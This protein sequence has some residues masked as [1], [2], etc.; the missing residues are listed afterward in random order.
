MNVGL[1]GEVFASQNGNF[2][3]VLDIEQCDSTIASTSVPM[4]LRID[5]PSTFR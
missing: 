2:Q 1:M 3:T 5:R 4:T